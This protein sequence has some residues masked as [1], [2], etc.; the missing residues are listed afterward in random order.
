M[1]E[2]NVP[3]TPITAWRVWYNTRTD[4]HPAVLVVKREDV[5]QFEEDEVTFLV[6]M[7]PNDPAVEAVSHID[8]L[9]DGKGYRWFMHR[10]DAYA[11]A[12]L[13]QQRHI[14]YLLACVSH[15]ASVA[16]IYISE[17]EDPNPN[18]V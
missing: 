7:R 8:S 5:I 14:R 18:R 9:D 17:S 13:Q 15:A 12:A 16:E 11:F 3:T 10:R 6:D 4:S 2:D 1:S